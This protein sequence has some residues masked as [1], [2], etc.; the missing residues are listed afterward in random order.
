MSDT[1]ISA[2]TAATEVF[3]AN[4][5]VIVQGGA[6]RRAAKSLFLT[7]ATGEDAVLTGSAGQFVG[8]VVDSTL[9]ALFFNDGGQLTITCVDMT[10]TGGPTAAAIAAIDAAGAW[11]VQYEDG[12]EILLTN[13]AAT[14]QLRLG[15]SGGAGSAFIDPD[16]IAMTYVPT[17][18][19]D[20]NG[21]APTDIA[22]A[23][24]RCAAL[25]K[26]LNGGVGP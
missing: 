16:G 6:N 5:T 26:F 15:T 8:L 20:W 7:G 2:L 21:A 13:A 11:V 14:K 23:I 3:A 12:E 24:D 22:V 18:A 19:T 9:G 25:L 4:E 10:I 17:T 1:K